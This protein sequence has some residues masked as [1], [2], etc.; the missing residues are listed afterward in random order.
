M[1]ATAFFLAASLTGVAPALA[2]T[3][4][5]SAPVAVEAPLAQA[6]TQ[7]A[8]HGFT[9]MLDL[10]LGVQHDGGLG[11]SAVGLAGLNLGVG[12]FLT[13]DLA[14]MFR[15]SGTNVMYDVAGFGNLSQVSGVGGIALQYWP[16]DRFNV[17]GGVGLGFWHAG[18]MFGTEQ[19]G[20]GVI[21]AGNV[22]LLTRGRHTLQVGAEYAPAFTDWGT[23][24]NV[25]FTLGYQYHR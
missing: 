24:Q 1:R 7:A 22:V 4:S 6:A 25:G 8:R 11:E 10:G 15:I 5:A 16:T 20:F 21:A 13:E 9:V 23:I 19:Q 14:L 17:E 3:P 12:G 2:Q 18:G